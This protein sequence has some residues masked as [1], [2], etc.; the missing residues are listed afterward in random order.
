M[1]YW[2]EKSVT[3]NNCRLMLRLLR[4]NMNSLLMLLK[5]KHHKIN[6]KKE[7]TFTNLWYLNMKWTD[8]RIWRHKHRYRGAIMRIILFWFFCRFVSNNSIYRTDT[9]NIFLVTNILAE[10]SISDLPCKHGWVLL[11]VLTYSIYHIRG[12]YFGLGTSNDPGTNG[13]CFVIPAK[14]NSRWWLYL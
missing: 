11:L 9:W 5:E 2:G 8:I 7:T 3:L 1:Q 13:A 6:F 14:L 4:L 12:S 10:Q